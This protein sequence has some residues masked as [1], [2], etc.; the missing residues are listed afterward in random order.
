MGKV[1]YD[2]PVEL[3]FA[4]SAQA[5]I[6]NGMKYVK[7]IIEE[8]DKFHRTNRSYMDEYLRD[9]SQLSDK[10]YE[11]G[12]EIRRYYQSYTMK[13]LVKEKLHSFDAEAM[14]IAS[15]EKITSPYQIAVICSL[16]TSYQKAVERDNIENRIKFAQGGHAGVV[17]ETV[18]LEVEV[19]KRVWSSNY[20]VWYLTGITTNDEVVFFPFRDCVQLGITLKIKCKV[21][22]HRDR[23]SLTQLSGVRL[24]KE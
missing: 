18:Q 22:A 6:N 16:P 13:I 17:G 2:F 8:E 7:T 5:A 23:D 3:V 24:I 10:A 15:L 9:P 1:V 21:K 20:Q 4:A 19:L 11:L 14:K 12:A